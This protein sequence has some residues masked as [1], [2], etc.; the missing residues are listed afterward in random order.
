MQAPANLRSWRSVSHIEHTTC[1]IDSATSAFFPRSNAG[2]DISDSLSLRQSLH[3]FA[4]CEGRSAYCGSSSEQV[5]LHSPYQHR[6]VASGIS[7]REDGSEQLHLMS[8]PAVSHHVSV[9]RLRLAIAGFHSR[10]REDFAWSRFFPRSV[11]FGPTVSVA[12][13]AFTIA[14]SMLCQRQAIPSNSSYSASPFRQSCTN[15][16]WRFHS[17]KYLWIELGLPYTSLGIAFHWQPVRNTYMM[18]SNT[19]RG[20][21]DF[22]PPP[23]RRRYRF[24]FERLPFGTSGSTRLHSSS[25][26][27]HDFIAPMDALYHSASQR[28]SVIYG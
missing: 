16:F 27:V 24:F 6:D 7:F 14:P 2:I 19:L 18:P 28:S 5:H 15:T 10:R 3:A 1:G 11:G 13:G 8:V 17:R 23:G 26:T 22:L 20:S 12:R 4:E 9:P 25:D 21:M